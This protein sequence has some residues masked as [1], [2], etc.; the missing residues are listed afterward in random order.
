M[1][2][3]RHASTALAILLLAAPAAS[4]AGDRERALQGSLS[5]I[6]FAVGPG[7]AGAVNHNND[8]HW[9][10]YAFDFD[11]GRPFGEIVCQALHAR[12]EG[13][14]GQLRNSRGSGFL[15][16]QEQTYDLAQRRARWGPLDPNDVYPGFD[17]EFPEFDY[18]LRTLRRPLEW[19]R[20][21]DGT[22]LAEI[23]ATS[24]GAAVFPQILLTNK[25]RLGQDS[26]FV[27]GCLSVTT[28]LDLIPLRRQTERRLLRHLL[29]DL[30]T[31]LAALAPP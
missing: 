23:Y 31:R 20:T 16:T 7:E 19:N 14:A 2:A 12:P 13:T 30:L 25:G 9:I 29:A 17:D 22:T 15:V 28:D 21:A 27:A 18:V 5:G 26:L 11:P 24:A 4:A 8:G 10:A 6:G 1:T 3:I